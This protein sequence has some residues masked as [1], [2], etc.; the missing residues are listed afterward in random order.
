M[1]V[2]FTSGPRNMI[3]INHE[4]KVGPSPIEIYEREKAE[5]LKREKS[6]AESDKT[7]TPKEE[8]S[9]DKESKD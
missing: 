9:D 6:E 3:D 4:V 1:P 5:K 7:D 2:M 8:Y